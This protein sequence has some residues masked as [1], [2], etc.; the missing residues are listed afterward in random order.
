MMFT[1]KSNNNLKA[2]LIA[3]TDGMD[4]PSYSS[5]VDID[6]HKK[7]LNNMGYFV[8]LFVIGLGEE[9]ARELKRLAEYADM[10]VPVANVNVL[11]QALMKCCACLQ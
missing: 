1:L 9:G 5:I 4:N 11:Y 3:I 6:R 2:A 10:C 7:V 8:K